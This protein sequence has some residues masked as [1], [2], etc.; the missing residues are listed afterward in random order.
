MAS[1]PLPPSESPPPPPPPAVS[2][3]SPLAAWFQHSG[4]PGKLLMFGGLVGIL[5]LIVALL[6]IG[7]LSSYGILALLAFIGCV[8]A[9]WFVYAPQAQ[10]QRKTWLYVALGCAALAGLFGLWILILSLKYVFTFESLLI[11]AAAVAV[12][13]GAILEARAQKLF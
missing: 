11:F 12:V 1:D 5:V 13:V 8:A 9:A 6:R 3:P 7:A 10:S 2:G 4:M